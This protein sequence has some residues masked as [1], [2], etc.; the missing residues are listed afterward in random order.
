M[1]DR[2]FRSEHVL[3]EYRGI[4]WIDISAVSTKI[5]ILVTPVQ[6]WQSIPRHHR[7][8]V[9]YNVQIIVQ[10]NQRQKPFIFDNNST[11][12]R[13]VVSTMLQKCPDFQ[14]RQRTINRNQPSPNWHISYEAEP[15][16]N[17]SHSGNMKH[18]TQ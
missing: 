16:D 5:A 8:H 13:M 6:V 18:P 10:K 11:S 15:Q 12:G 4:R 17:R 3:T 9:M 1:W 14:N 2:I 7:M